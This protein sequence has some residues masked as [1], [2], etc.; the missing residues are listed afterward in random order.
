MAAALAL[1]ALRLALLS[2]ALPSAQIAWGRPDDRAVA[3][4]LGLDDLCAASAAAPACALSALQLRGGTLGGEA[5]AARPAHDS[6][7]PRASAAGR[8]RRQSS[9]GDLTRTEESKFNHEIN[10]TR[11]QL[12]NLTKTLA[13]LEGYENKTRLMVLTRLAN[14]SLEEAV[15][16]SRWEPGGKRL[17]MQQRGQLALGAGRR[18]RSGIGKRAVRLRHVVKALDSLQEDL[19]GFRQR[20]AFCERLNSWTV[21]KIRDP[22]TRDLEDGREEADDEALLAGLASEAGPLAAKKELEEELASVKGQTTYV[23]KK[24]KSV[25][26]KA[27]QTRKFYFRKLEGKTEVEL[28]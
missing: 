23:T 11:G 9:L 22:N 21:A 27:E 15:S 10:K 26:H 14:T 28:P 8:R 16:G 20:I 25:R 2:A 7:A 24:V 19:T 17:V 4:S 13:A 3:A 12:A 6:S 1:P 18:R 5:A